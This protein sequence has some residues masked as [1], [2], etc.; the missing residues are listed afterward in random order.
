MTSGL[1]PQKTW[2]T[3]KIAKVSLAK[4]AEERSLFD[5][6]TGTGTSWATRP[7]GA[8]GPISLA[9]ALNILRQV[10]KDAADGAQR[11]DFLV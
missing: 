5:T 7:D 8:G 10:V 4:A 1:A 2:P 3:S 6:A 9:V 11:W